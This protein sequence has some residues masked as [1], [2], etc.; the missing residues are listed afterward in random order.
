MKFLLTIIALLFCISLNAMDQP[1]EEL[2]LP[3]LLKNPMLR[4]GIKSDIPSIQ[5]VLN[6]IATIQENNDK[7]IETALSH[8]PLTLRTHTIWKL[9]Q[10]QTQL[11]IEEKEEE[12]IKATLYLMKI[13]AILILDVF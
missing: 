6:V 1:K 4:N 11:I 9:F 12:V 7:H 10:T 8:V 2:K 5:Q 3:P 13:I